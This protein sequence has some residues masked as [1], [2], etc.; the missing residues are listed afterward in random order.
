MTYSY[1][2][3]HIVH[4]VKAVV[5]ILFV[6][7]LAFIMK[8]ILGEFFLPAEGTVFAVGIIYA[9][10]KYAQGQSHTVTLD[11][12]EIIYTTGI[13]TMKKFVLPYGKVTETNY[14]QTIVQ[15]LFGLGNL[16]VDTPGGTDMVLRLS[17]VPINDIDMTLNAIKKKQ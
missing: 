13:A 12:N 11:E 1:H 7:F 3:S 6:G 8:G 16:S 14:S 17:D 2:P 10:M 5:F 4:I 15:R 9:A